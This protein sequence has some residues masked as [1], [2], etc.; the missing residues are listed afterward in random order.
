MSLIART[1]HLFILYILNFP[2]MH[3]QFGSFIV[4]GGYSKNAR[5]HLAGTPGR[6]DFRTPGRQDAGMPAFV[7]AINAR[8]SAAKISFK[9]LHAASEFCRPPAKTAI[10]RAKG[11]VA[12]RLG[13]WEAEGRELSLGW[14]NSTLARL[15]KKFIQPTVVVVV[16]VV[17][18]E[19]RSL[20]FRCFDKVA[21]NLAKYFIRLLSLCQRVYL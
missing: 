21:P 20:Q 9:F 8:L 10:C 18:G 17:V 14:G 16:V 1:L 5:G 2:L 19:G 7:G 12:G 4:I 15:L 11:G 13:G 3:I 6:Q